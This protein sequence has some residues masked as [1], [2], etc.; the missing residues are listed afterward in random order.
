MTALKRKAEDQ[1]LSAT[2]NII[3]EALASSTPDLNIELPGIDGLEKIVQ[4]A[5]AKASGTA[6]HQ[7]ATTS[8]DFVLPPTCLLTVR[9]EDFVM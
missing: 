9:E 4:R 2:Q 8:S 6:N 7:E 1:Q 3:T 5:R